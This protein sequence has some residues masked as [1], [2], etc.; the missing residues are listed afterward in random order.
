MS[1]S[2]DAAR[3]ATLHKY[4][5]N[6]VQWIIVNHLSACFLVANCHP[7]LCCLLVSGR[8]ESRGWFC[9]LVTW[10]VV[11][12]LVV[13]VNSCGGERGCH[14]KFITICWSFCKMDRMC[15]LF[16]CWGWCWENEL[17]QQRQEQ[18]ASRNKKKWGD[19]VVGGARGKAGGDGQ[20]ERQTDVDRT[21]TKRKLPG[22]LAWLAVSVSL[23]RYNLHVPAIK[24][25]W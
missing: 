12:V 2:M 24:G 6:I 15:L 19:V 3:T 5:G 13:T 18:R 25:I 16:V 22:W 7:C 21:R 9:G 17:L 20:T 8:V 10:L 1:T 4:T 23:C 14:T 11:L